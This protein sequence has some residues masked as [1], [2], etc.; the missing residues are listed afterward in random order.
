VEQLLEPLAVLD[1]IDRLP[2][3]R[4]RRQPRVVDRRVDSRPGAGVD[5]RQTRRQRRDV[6][7]CAA[8]LRRRVRRGLCHLQPPLAEF[9][10]RRQLRQELLD[11]QPAV[12]QVIDVE[13]AARFVGVAPEE[14]RERSSYQCIGLGLGP[15]GVGHVC[16]LRSGRTQVPPRRERPLSVG[17]VRCA[18]QAGLPGAQPGAGRSCKSSTDARGQVNGA[19]VSLAPGQARSRSTVGHGDWRPAATWQGV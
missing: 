17:S 12:H 2:R 7:L 13:A 10:A 8:D 6:R 1:E 19:A 3:N 5:R 18:K 4:V 9:R 15:D 16:L 14:R 11:G